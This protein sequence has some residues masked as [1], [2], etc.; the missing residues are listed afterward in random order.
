MYL[1]LIIS[2]F[3]L[4]LLFSCFCKTTAKA[5]S[6]LETRVPAKRMPITRIT[7]PPI[8][9]GL[10]DE[11]VWQQLV[12]IDDLH[13]LRPNEFA[14][15]T[16][17]SQF[18]LAYD[19][20]MLYIAARLF[21][22]E[23]DLISLRE[24][25]Q[26]KSFDSDDLI[27][28]SLDPFNRN[29]Q[30]YLFKVNPFGLRYEALITN[31]E[32]EVNEDWQ[33]IWFAAASIDEQGW[34]VEL[35]IP[36]KSLSF[37]PNSDTWG[38]NLGRV[39]RR[40]GEILAWS[41]Q[42][43]NA[44]E[45]APALMG[46]LSPIEKINQG[47]GLDIKVSG[48]AS[49]MDKAMEDSTDQEAEPSL[50]IFYK[51]KPALTVVG[52]IN[53]D[54]SAT[55]IDD[56]RVNTGRFS[57]KMAEKRDFFLQDANLY[58]FADLSDNGTPF[59]TRRIGLDRKGQAIPLNGGV[60]LSGRFDNYNLGLLAMQQQASGGMENDADLFVLRAS[61]N[62]LAESNLGVIYTKGDPLSDDKNE[63]MGVDFNYNNSKAFGNKLVQASA[64]YQQSEDDSSESDNRAY[65][66][67][68]AYPNSRMKLA[69]VH[70]TIEKNFNPA[71]GFVNRKDISRHDFSVR[72]KHYLQHNWLMHYEPSADY[73]MV[74]NTDGEK[75]NRYYHF[76]PFRLESIQ[77]DIIKIGFSSWKDTVDRPFT[78]VP[79]FTVQPGY[80]ENDTYWYLQLKSATSRAL[81][82][83]TSTWR[84]DFYGAE[85]LTHRTELG[86]R[87]LQAWLLHAKHEIKEYDFDDSEFTLRIY[88][89]RSELAIT[90]GW[91]WFL[92]GQFD[93]KSNYLGVQSRL[94]WL[95]QADREVFFVVNKGMIRD[96]NDDFESLN[97]EY[98]FK[99]SYTFRF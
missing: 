62:V 20:D 78:P 27:S 88:T 63:V 40:K 14:A 49:R 38:I 19:D 73:E 76:S 74:D 43:D 10:L 75:L 71:M 92:I 18:W 12:P 33:A 13:Q 46:K 23:P 67:T 59:Y 65:G 2:P 54:F 53:T 57:L 39:I 69:W 4:V 80:Y 3:L 6:L 42:G 16:E 94:R 61:R 82:F 26:G 44:W 70:N 85:H 93:N 77:G 66:F 29:R 28:I 99:A 56:L 51:P 60:K 25:I 8:V 68:L 30:G 58:A 96:D 79:G 32:D 86:W 22:T 52:T 47:L 24:T 1:K 90:R 36:F 34:A 84:D 48:V 83:K 41:S 64:W 37:D 35:A 72:Y 98:T 87:P 11:P 45:N 5:D 91:A 81:Y 21:D 89:L 50:D 97:D 55:E 7:T 9:D 17:H 95:P 31:L 15:P